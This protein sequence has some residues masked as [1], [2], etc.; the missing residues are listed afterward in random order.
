MIANHPHLFCEIVLVYV[1][2]HVLPNNPLHPA[3]K[4][5]S[6]VDELLVPLDILPIPEQIAGARLL[7]LCGNSPQSLIWVSVV[8]LTR[9]AALGWEVILWRRKKFEHLGMIHSY[10]GHGC[11]WGVHFCSSFRGCGLIFLV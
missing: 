11:S 4:A 10:R 7:Q 8:D 1:H 2:C 9:P 5:T 3:D 6:D